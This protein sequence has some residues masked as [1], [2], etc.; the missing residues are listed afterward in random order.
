MMTEYGWQRSTTLRTHVAASRTP[1]PKAVFRTETNV[2]ALMTHD[3]AAD[4]RW[5]KGRGIKCHGVAK[6]AAHRS[7]QLEYTRDALIQLV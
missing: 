3:I 5:L 7:A 1:I 6:P 4:V 2:T